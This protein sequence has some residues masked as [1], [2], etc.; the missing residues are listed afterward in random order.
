MMKLSIFTDEI[1]ADPQ[2]AMALAA[3]W[4]IPAIEVRG[5]P[6]GRFPRVADQELET[7]YK[8]A[9]DAGLV[10]SGVSPGLFKCPVGE[11]AVSGDIESLLPRSCEWAKKWG[12]DI[13][14][15]FAFLRD[16]SNQVPSVVI[17][18]LGQMAEVAS[19]HHS[20]RFAFLG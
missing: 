13:V 6:G 15:I 3:E 9:I 16:E 18:R 17:D 5:L 4:N 7:F 12:T 8:M 2:R 19:A 10:V 14:S 20:R 11:A 1:N